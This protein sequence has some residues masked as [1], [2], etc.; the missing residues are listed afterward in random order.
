TE[1][2]RL[3]PRLGLAIAVNV[4]PGSCQLRASPARVIGMALS[5]SRV[6]GAYTLSK[7]SCLIQDKA[8]YSRR[9][10]DRSTRFLRV[11]LPART[12]VPGTHRRVRRRAGRR[13]L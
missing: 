13:R 2:S 3:R 7:A 6:L 4:A 8:L 10:R 11:G 1:T 5:C 9:C 12:V